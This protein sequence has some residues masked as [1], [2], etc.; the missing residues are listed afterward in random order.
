MRMKKY[1]VAFIALS[2]VLAIPAIA[3]AQGEY[4]DVITDEEGDVF[5]W[6]G[7]GWDYNVERPNIDIIR[8]E[9]SESGGTVTISLTVKGEITD[10]E[11]ILYYMYLTDGEDG[12]YSFFYNDDYGYIIASSDKGYRNF[13]P[14]IS[15]AGTD[16]LSVSCSLEDLLTPDMLRFT[17]VATYEYTEDGWYQDTASPKDLE[18]LPI[19]YELDVEPTIGEAPLE[20]QI[21]F[22][23]E[24]TGDADGQIPLTVD[25]E[26]IYTMELG[27]QESKSENIQH[28]FEE[29][30]IYTVE[31]G[32][33]SVTVYAEGD[34]DDETP[35][36]PYSDVV[37]DPEGDVMRLVGPTED[38]WEYVESPDVDLIQIEISESGGLVTVS[39]R[40]KGTIR[41]DPGIYYEIFMK[42]DSN[43]EFDIWYNDGDCQ[44]TAYM[45]YDTGGFGNIFEPAV[46]GVGTDTLRFAFT[47]EQIG[48]PEVLLIS[49][50]VAL[51]EPD[52]EVD[53]AGPDAEYP[54]DDNGYDNGDDNGDD[55]GITPPDDNGDDNGEYDNDY[56]DDIDEEFLEALWARGMWCM[57]MV[58]IIP[59]VVIVV[60]IV[61]VFKVMKSGDKKD[62]QQYQQPPPQQETRP[63]SQDQSGPEENPP[64]PPPQD[65]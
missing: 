16:T 48:S 57:A 50:V 61:I 45:E 24:N 54:G 28:N 12:Y 65:R 7:T 38:D 35:D 31:F 37:N 30:G 22:G 63:P 62:E 10:G 58:I 51:N 15:G 32:D 14:D 49:E 1:I 47:R 19:D 26:P 46:D 6:H 21:T 55:N 59:L 39:L 9:I 13:E 5:H 53:L 2:L 11:D 43:G 17:S 33:Q 41:D 60:I 56:Y 44:M 27:A 25:G 3:N 36:S 23:A 34:S 52:S 64:P 18:F 40:V 8:A 4:S 42:D 29:P 20:V